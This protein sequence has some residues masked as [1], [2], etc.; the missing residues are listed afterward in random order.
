MDHGDSVS[1]FPALMGT[2]PV[3]KKGSKG[4]KSKKAST[5]LD[6]L[7]K[8]IFPGMLSTRPPPTTSLIGEAEPHIFL[9]FNASHVVLDGPG[10]EPTVPVTGEEEHQRFGP[11][12]HLTVTAP[13]DYL[14]SQA[15]A[16]MHYPAS[17]ERLYNQTYDDIPAVSDD[18]ARL[19]TPK[20]TGCRVGTPGRPGTGL[21]ENSLTEDERTYTKM[22]D[23]Y[24][25]HNFILWNGEPQ[26]STP[27][28]QSF[29]RSY[30]QNWPLVSMVLGRLQDFIKRKKWKLV[31]IRG[32]KLLSVGRKGKQHDDYALE[33]CIAKVGDKGSS[34]VPRPENDDDGRHGAAV[35]TQRYCRGWQG[36]R[37]VR[38]LRR[39]ILAAIVVQA[40]ARRFIQVRYK[41]RPRLLAMKE[42]RAQFF[43]AN[44]QRLQ[45]MWHSV[46][47]SPRLLI[48][49]P[50]I[51][52]PEIVRINMGDFQALQNLLLPY[53]HHLSDPDL[54][55][56]YITPRQI[57]KFELTYHERLLSLMGISVSTK[58]LHFLAPEFASLV[59]PHTALAQS[60]WYSA[61]LLRELRRKLKKFGDR[62]VLVTA[63]EGW[64]ERRVAHYLG[65]SILG[66]SDNIAGRLCAPP[67]ARRLFKDASVNVPMG[68]REI[69]TKD[70]ILLTL[71][72]LVSTYLDTDTWVLKLSNTY[73]ADAAVRFD[74]KKLGPLHEL[75]RRFK[76][77]EV[78]VGGKDYR[79]FQ[80]TIMRDVMTILREGFSKCTS[81]VDKANYPS[82]SVF[83]TVLKAYGGI[84]EALPAASSKPRA[85]FS[86][87]FIDPHG[88]ITVEKGLESITSSDSGLEHAVAYPQ[89]VVSVDA[90]EGATRS[91]AKTLWDHH[92]TVGYV[93][94]RYVAFEDKA[95]QYPLLWAQGV[96]L[97]CT[98]HHAT[99]SALRK[100]GTPGHV[101]VGS[102]L[103][104]FR[105]DTDRAYVHVPFAF[106][107][108]LVGVR[109]DLFFKLCGLHGV[110]YDM[111]SRQGVLFFLGESVVGGT[112]NVMAVA[113]DVGKACELMLAALTFIMS[114]FSNAASADLSK[115][116]S[117]MGIGAVQLTMKKA[118]RMFTKP[119]TS[120]I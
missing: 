67:C 70:D 41:L 55:L 117:P 80:M 114:K 44:L 33:G 115:A 56:V 111:E 30:E 3:S 53:L 26:T 71:T 58:R 21:E 23:Q 110:T 93:T 78:S 50:S 106:A 68:S 17:P 90:L 20:A 72:T 59:A 14:G 18:Y 9:G 98:P 40:Q 35:H 37:R 46:P 29:R 77:G 76:N 86:M 84:I 64:A 89:K 10:T 39:Q 91:V 92:G 102:F 51:S 12:A 54:H 107:T 104:E 95:V 15:E 118:V 28:F 105:E 75:R 4:K 36:R 99:V 120:T 96:V 109:D 42:A 74:V 97:G 82:F 63:I 2:K 19:R 73:K 27:E 38:L 81:M 52:L 32:G 69:F 5:E 45:A 88:N 25:L 48:V 66:G 85:L 13:F 108:Q 57:G 119:L 31:I 83:L 61:G 6:G 49:V 60:M 79:H 100:L 7:F 62:V 1:L 34:F 16:G 43:G 11:V 87:C 101:S 103:E 116:A 24:S 47:G 22:M 113:S 65:V 8:E 94:V 112:L